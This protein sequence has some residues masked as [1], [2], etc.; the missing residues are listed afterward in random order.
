MPRPNRA[1]FVSIPLGLG[2]GKAH[3]FVFLGNPFKPIVPVPS[4]DL[5]QESPSC[6]PCLRKGTPA[7]TPATVG[8]PQMEASLPLAE[9][10]PVEAHN[11][12]GKL[13]LPSI[14]SRGESSSSS[15]PLWDRGL[16]GKWDPS[17]VLWNRC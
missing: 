9:F 14:S 2:L 13:S 16:R 1:R 8:T 10:P 11:P 17:L 5:G 4:N 6:L 12:Q 3:V 15:T 7:S